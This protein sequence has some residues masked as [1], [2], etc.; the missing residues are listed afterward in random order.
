MTYFDKY[1]SNTLA[2][3]SNQCFFLSD[4]KSRKGRIFYRVFEKG[5]YNYSFLFTNTVDSTYADGTASYKNKVCEEW[6]I[7][8]LRV[9]CCD[10]I[11]NSVPEEAFKDVT[12]NGKKTKTVAEAEMFYT[13]PVLIAPTEY[14]LIE[15][16]FKGTMM[17]YHEELIISAFTEEN[18]RWSSDRRVPVPSMVGCD[19]R[20]KKQIGFL[21]D[22]ITQGCG[23]K[24]DSYSHWN[25]VLSEMLGHQYAYWN[26]G[27]GYGRASDAASDGAWLKKA[28]NNDV[29]FVCF[30][31]NDILFSAKE[32]DIRANIKNIVEILKKEGITVI[33]QTIPPFDYKDGDIEK[34]KRINEYIKTELSLIADAVFD[35]VPV[36][37]KSNEAS[38]MAAYGGHPNAEGCL[39]WAEALYDEIKQ[40]VEE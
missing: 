37:R 7:E 16:S 34:W 10:A 28:K 32:E 31:V 23:T 17:P 40:I 2:G 35:N 36:L 3:S 14:V 4:G 39:I 27:I 6:Q 1:K 22:S 26:L 19:R 18:G 5:E 9:A 38:H 21:G 25:A 24:N 30:G 29:V 15:I 12:F 33:L 20:V 13:D 8:G 11:D